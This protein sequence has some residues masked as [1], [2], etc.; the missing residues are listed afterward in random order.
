MT[1][2]KDPMKRL[3]IDIETSAMR[4]RF[5]GLWDQNIGLNQLENPTQMLSFAAKWYGQKK[6]YFFAE[7]EVGK[8]AMVKAA[9]DLLDEANVLI[10]FNGDKF[11]RRHLNREFHEER[12][13]P[14]SPYQQIDLMKVAKK[15][16][17][18]PSNKLEYILRWNGF[19]GKVQHSGFGLWTAVESGDQKA[20]ALFKKYNIGDVVKLEPLYDELKPWIENHPNMQLFVPR[21]EEP[22]CPTCGS[23][24]YNLDG[25]AAR[26]NLSRVQRYKCKD[27]NRGFS[28]RLS[29]IRA[30]ER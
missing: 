28:G 14:P 25:T 17:Y 7:Y 18:L 24:N 3:I 10:H 30:E 20:R 9:W 22:S 1:R 19:E 4:G 26:G 16:F 27:C 15:Y 23:T 29:V 13:G 21:G 6:T 8:S 11:D 12:L 2:I 5:W